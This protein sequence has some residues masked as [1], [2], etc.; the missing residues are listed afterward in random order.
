[1]PARALASKAWQALPAIMAWVVAAGAVLLAI[2]AIPS[3]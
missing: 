2:R 3:L 1:V